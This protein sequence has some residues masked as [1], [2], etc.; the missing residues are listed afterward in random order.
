[1]KI[2][3]FDGGENSRLRPQMLQQNEGVVYEN[4]DNEKGTLTPV[5]A[6]TDTGQASAKFPYFYHDK[7]TW[8]SSATRRSYVEFTKILYYTDGVSRPQKFDG[9]N[10]YNLGISKPSTAPGLTVT[11]APDTPQA[12]DLVPGSAGDLP[13]TVHYYLIINKDTSLYSA[14]LYMSIDLVTDRVVYLTGLVSNE[15]G[16]N[17]A[18]I[19]TQLN[20]ASTVTRSLEIS[21]VKDIVYGAGGVEVYRLSGDTYRLIG[22]LASDASTVT[23]SVYDISANA[24]FDDTLA[25]PLDGEALQYV[26]TFVNSADGTESA[27]SEATAETEVLGSIELTGLQVSTD[28]QVDKRR[29]YRIGGLLSAYSLVAEIDNAV[30]TYNDTTKDTAI[31][32]TILTAANNVEAPTGL[33]HLVEAY[34]M[35]FGAEGSKLRFTPI[36]EPNYWSE[37]FFLQY[38]TPITGIAPTSNGV[39]VFT[40]F[41]SYIVTGTGPTTLSSYPLSNSQGCVDGSSIQLVGGAAIWASSDG[42]CM[43][44]GS[45]VRVLTRPKLGKIALSPVDSILHDDVYYLIEDTG[46]ILAIDYRYNEVI[47]RLSLGVEAFAIAND[48][49]YGYYN[50]TLHTLFSSSAFETFK[51]TSPRFIEGSSSEQKTYK[52]VY[53]YSKGDIIISILIDDVIVRTKTLTTEDSHQIQVPQDKQRGH[54]IQFQIEGTGEVYEIEYTT[55]RRQNE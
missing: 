30:T 19:I 9:T 13:Q 31:V 21:N 46:N 15:K 32:G 18:N 53:L 23:D 28:P 20:I 6:K 2:Q 44:N 7:Q 12:V 36:G 48:V 33:A 14:P 45:N 22:T 3:T 5:L 17:S 25:A 4:I 11:S 50:S 55:G 10:T 24:A 49:L 43:S 40:E 38:S 39:I 8:L 34:A 37:F 1:M 47:K 42:I 29:I 35:F 16:S 26:Y 51:Y 52:K 41:K 54:F 27:P